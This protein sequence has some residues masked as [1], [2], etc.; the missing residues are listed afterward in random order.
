MKLLVVRHGQTVFNREQRYLGAL[1]PPL[2][3]IGLDQAKAISKRLPKPLNLVACSPLLRATQTAAVI[4]SERA[5]D[6]EV[7]HSFRE[8]HVGV[9]E[10]LTQ[11]EAKQKYPEIWATGAT[12]CWDAAP[13]GGE[14]IHE[15][16]RR[17]FD[18]LMYIYGSFPDGVV[19]LVAHG[20]VAKTIRAL[21]VVGFADFFQW[22]LQ[23]GEILEI[24]VP[25]KSIILRPPL[26]NPL[27]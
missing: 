12:R 13:P 4:C 18:G 10:G 19:T 5:L 14:T 21:C 8:R 27:P 17:V 15:V 16:A 7:I 1:N 24:D 22:Q 9:Y 20:F 2:D 6:A 23:N 11:Q 25:D 3:E 26:C